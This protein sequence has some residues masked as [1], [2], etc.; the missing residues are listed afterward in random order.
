MVVVVSVVYQS[1]V[2]AEEGAGHDAG[3]SLPSSAA[4]SEGEPADQDT[5]GPF[6]PSLPSPRTV[7]W[8][9]EVASCEDYCIPSFEASRR[10]GTVL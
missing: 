3:T 2:G 10:D 8:A 4:S 9:D 6:R 7:T 5:R 1:C